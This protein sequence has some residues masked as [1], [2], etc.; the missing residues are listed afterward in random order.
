MLAVVVSTDLMLI[1]R[2]ALRL[3]VYGSP[4]PAADSMIRAIAVAAQLRRRCAGR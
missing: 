1:I 4:D 2:R 3:E